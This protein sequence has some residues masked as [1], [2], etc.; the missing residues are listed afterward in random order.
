MGKTLYFA[1]VIFIFFFRFSS[2]ILSSRTLD[3]YHTSTHDVALVQIQNAGL[4]YAACSSLKIQD[5]SPKIRHPCTTIRKKN[6]L[7][8]NISSTSSQYGEL[9]PTS[10]CDL[11]ASLEHPSKFQQRRVSASLLH[12]H[13][14]TEVNQTLHDVWPSLLGWST[15]YIWGALAP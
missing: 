10:G 5:A 1:A 11:L 2:P 9:R 4:K 7:N 3:V 6:L 12:R 13:R 15:V 14:S 8:S